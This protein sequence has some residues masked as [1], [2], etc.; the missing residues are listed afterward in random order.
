MI[1]PG[2]PY[3]LVNLGVVYE[4]EGQY[5]RAIRTYQQVINRYGGG[6]SGA[7]RV[8]PAVQPHLIKIAKENLN[9]AKNLR[10]K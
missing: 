10:Q 5:D 8:D 4:K 9:H 7:G 1:D 6:T 3:A 2:N